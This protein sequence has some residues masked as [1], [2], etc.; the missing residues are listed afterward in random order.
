M[1]HATRNC[2]QL[3][4]GDFLLVATNANPGDAIKTYGLRWE[5]ET[6][7][8]CL[9]GRGFN[10]EDTHIID[11]ERIK[12]LLVLLAVAFCWAHKIGEWQNMLKPIKIKKHGRPAISLFRYGLD[13]FVEAIVNMFCKIDLFKGCM[14]CIRISEAAFPMTERY[15]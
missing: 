1:T 3:S 7:F 2:L 15:F 10:F 14:D 6:L 8:S 11:Q 12:K 4:A 9:K 5:I 13:Y